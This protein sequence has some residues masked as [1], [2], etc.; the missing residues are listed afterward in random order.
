MPADDVFVQNLQAG[1]ALCMRF[2]M[3]GVIRCA[4]ESGLTMA[5]LGALLQIERRPAGGVSDL[6]DHLGISHAAASQLLEGLVQLGLA[7]RAEDLHDRRQRQI[8]LTAQGQ[9]VLAGVL[10]AR[11]RWLETFAG[12]LSPGERGLTLQALRLFIEKAEQLGPGQAA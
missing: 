7:T 4:K 11:Q 8:S 1:L 2:S 5:Q 3:G 10:R 12:E 6:G 9:Q